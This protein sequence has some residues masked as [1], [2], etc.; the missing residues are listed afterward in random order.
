[1]TDAN[2]AL[3]YLGAGGLVGGRVTLDRALAERAIREHVAEPLGLSLRDAAL[4]VIRVVNVNMEVGLRLSLSE[5]GL[6]HRSFALVAFGGAGPLHATRVARNVGIPRVLVPPYPG[7]SCAMGLLQ[8]D[9]RHFYLRSRLAPLNALSADEMTHIFDELED[10]ARAEARDEGFDVAELRLER[11][12]ALRYPFQG[13]ELTV[14]MESGPIEDASRDLLRKAFDTLH[15]QV[16]GTSAPQE[17]PEVVNLRI[18]ASNP[19][20]RLSLPVLGAGDRS[21]EAAWVGVRSMILEES[22]D[23]LDVN[24]YRRDQLL[25]GNVIDGPAVIE[26]LDSTTLLLPGQQATVDRF[27][28]LLV[29]VE[30]K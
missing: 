12:V 15:Q 28:T 25:A 30:A 27:G 11:Q 10:R 29:D 3:G 14:P 5:R 9:V 7:I 8:T 18:E 13:Y 17:T 20:P 1:V 6:D 19:V 2:L 23:S 16:Y 24:V 26:Q 21:P 4:G 22:A